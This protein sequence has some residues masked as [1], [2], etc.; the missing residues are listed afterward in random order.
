MTTRSNDYGSKMPWLSFPYDETY[1]PKD[2]ELPDP[3][4]DPLIFGSR[5]TLDKVGING[6]DLPIKF[7]RRDGTAEQ[8]YVKASLYGSLDDPNIKGLNQLSNRAQPSQEEIHILR[9]IAKA[10]LRAAEQASR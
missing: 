2:S 4:M 6:V 3:Q 8:L 5:T 9:G 7:L 10:M 1:Y